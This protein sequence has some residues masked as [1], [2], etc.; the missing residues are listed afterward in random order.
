MENQLFWLHEKSLILGNEEAEKWSLSL[1][2]EN[3]NMETQTVKG[4]IVVLG[5]PNTEQGELYSIAKER[6]ELT[7]TEYAN[8]PDYD[9][10]LTGGY[11]SHFNNTDKPHAAY[12]KRY[13]ISRGIPEDHI[14]EF[15]E[16]SNTFE[17]ASLSK[18]I[19]LKYGVHNMLVITSDY[20]LDR[21][22]YIFEKEFADTDVTIK[23]SGSQTD[24][25]ACK[26]DLEALKRHEQE[27]LV[28][29]K[30]MKC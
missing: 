2:D 27:A 4:F 9:I 18:P 30:F 5:S 20:H 12:L 10:L 19:V 25:I 28:K 14:V 7:L 16:S 29:L 26:L 17:D 15:A 23:F 3:L 24:E 1:F 6:C 11:G 22:Q 13:L 21:A 8:N